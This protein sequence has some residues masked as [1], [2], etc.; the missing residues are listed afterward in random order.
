MNDEIMNQLQ[1]ARSYL[2][3]SIHSEF[4]GPLN[5]NDILVEN[6]VTRYAAG[7]LFPVNYEGRRDSEPG[8]PRAEAGR[9][10]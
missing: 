10:K 4:V 3:D 7:M 1:T 2:V 8:N 5:E 9:R 6:P